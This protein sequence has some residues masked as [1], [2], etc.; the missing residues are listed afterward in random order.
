MTRFLHVAAAQ[1]HSGGTVAQTLERMARQTGSAASAG[2]DVILFAEGALHGYDGDMTAASVRAQAEPVDGPGCLQIAAMAQRCK[3]TVL[4]GFFER[5][6]DRIYN[7]VLVAAPSGVCA[8]ARKHVLTP[9]E[10]NAELTPG[11]R[12]RHVVEINGVRGAII[13]C[14]D[15]GMPGLHQDLRTQGVDFRF[16]PTGGGGQA[17]DMLHERDLETEAARTFYIQNRQRVFKA[18]AILGKEECPVSGFASANALGPVGMRTCHQGHCMIVDNRRVMRAQ[19]AG[20]IVLE[21]MQDQF[22]HAKLSFP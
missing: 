1:I 18:A 12:A 17:E 21:H 11:P 9:G 5:D 15:E 2:A 22:I 16:C 19:I 3:L 8:A 4:A 14:A 7:S 20:T 13:I 6:H 10:L